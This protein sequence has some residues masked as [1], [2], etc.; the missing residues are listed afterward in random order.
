[1]EPSTESG[2]PCSQPLLVVLDRIDVRTM[3][4]KIRVIE[5]EVLL[6]DDERMENLAC[7]VK[8]KLGIVSEVGVLRCTAHSNTKITLVGSAEATRAL[9]ASGRASKP[10]GL[11]ISKEEFPIM[12]KGWPYRFATE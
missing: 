7:I 2:G 9:I 5:Y 1:M 12:I 11:V 6:W 10:G 8:E 4:D 3:P